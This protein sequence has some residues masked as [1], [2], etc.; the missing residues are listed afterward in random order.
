MSRSITLQANIFSRRERKDPMSRSIKAAEIP[1]GPLPTVEKEGSEQ[2]PEARVGTDVRTVEL[3]VGCIDSS[4]VAILGTCHPCYGGLS[5][6]TAAFES[7]LLFVSD[8][9]PTVL[10]VTPV[11]THW[12]YQGGHRCNCYFGLP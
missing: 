6:D 1:K 8:P 10:L 12:V 11:K 7:F 5:G 2:L 4:W 9:F 3:P